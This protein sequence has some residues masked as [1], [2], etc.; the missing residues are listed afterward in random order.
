MTGIRVAVFAS[1]VSLTGCGFVFKAVPS[2]PNYKQSLEPSLECDPTLWRHTH[3]RFR[4]KKI[5]GGECV[6]VTGVVERT[7][8]DIADGDLNVE[9]LPDEQYRF[10]VNRANYDGLLRAEIICQH[11]PA[12]WLIRHT[13]RTL[14]DQ[15]AVTVPSQ[16]A[17]I[18][19]IG[20]LV[21]D[22]WHHC[23]MEIHPVSHLI[24]RDP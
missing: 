18:E 2:M 14:M 10:L 5:P 3:H 11:R 12:S 1:A 17:H 23:Y 16:G 19:V 7:H 9:F 21:S 6:R 4:F 20:R 22:C 13:C 15:P 8:F 24:I